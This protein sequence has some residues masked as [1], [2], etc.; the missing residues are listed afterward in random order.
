MLAWSAVYFV[1]AWT[2][3]RHLLADPEYQAYVQKVRYRF[4][5]GIY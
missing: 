4:I 3:E 5:P 2:E 1:R